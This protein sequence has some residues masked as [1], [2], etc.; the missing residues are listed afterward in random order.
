MIKLNIWKKIFLFVFVVSMAAVGLTGYWGYYNGKKS[1]KKAALAQLV[2]IRD[3]KKRQ[4]ESY[5]DERLSDTEVLSGRNGLQDFLR[6]ISNIKSQPEN[7]GKLQKLDKKF[8]KQFDKTSAFIREKMGFY[9][10]FI[11]DTNGNIIY[12]AAKEDDLGS[13]LIHGK[14]NHSGLSRAYIKGLK[15][16]YISDFEFYGASN[17]K[18]SS[19]FG[20]PIKDDNGDVLGVFATQIVTDEINDIMQE[21]SGLG[22]TGETFLIGHDLF[23]RSDSRFYNEQTALIKKVEVEAPR[24]GLAGNTGTMWLLDYRNVPVLNAY[25]PINIPG[26]HWAIIAKMDET[27]ALA[28]AYRFRNLMLIGAGILAAIVLLVSYI[29]SRKITNPINIF[30]S[31]IQEMIRASQYNTAIPVISKDEVGLLV[32]SFNKM[33]SQINE[34]TNELENNQEN[35]KNE[36]TERKQAENELKR[37]QKLKAGL[38]DLSLV[39]QGEQSVST[40]AKNVI[41]C[42]VGFLK[43]PIAAFFVLNIQSKYHRVADFG[44]PGG[45]DLPDLF[46]PGEGYIGQAAKNGKPILVDNI[47]EHIKVGFGFGEIP[48]QSILLVPLIHNKLAIGVLELGSFE[49]FTTDQREWIEEAIKSISVVLRSNIDASERRRNAVLR[50]ED[51]A[52][53]KVAKQEADDANQAK[54]DFLANMSHEIRT[55]MNAIMGMSQLCLRTELTTKQQD[56]IQKTYSAARSLLGIINDILDFSK[57]EAGK[58]DIEKV[59]F[60]LEDIFNNLSNLITIKAQDKGL[61]FLFYISPDVPNF[62]KGD[63]LRLGQVL[64]NL[65][66]NA[67]KFT[68]SGEILVSV[69]VI[70]KS[71]HDATLQFSVKDSGIGMTKEQISNLF[72]PFS[73]ADTSTTRKYGGTGLGLTISKRLVEM[74]SGKIW[75]ESEYGNGSSFIFTAMLGISKTKDKAAEIHAAIP[76]LKGINVMVVDDNE[77]LQKLFEK[78]LTNLSFKVA[79]APTGETA[80]QLLEEADKNEPY[81]LLFMDFMLPGI[82]GIETTKQIKESAKIVNKPKVVMSTSRP[83]EE[84]EKQ[85]HG[86]EYDAYLFK[87]FSKSS[88]FDSIMTAYGRDKTIRSKVGAIPEAD[89]ASIEK[90]RGA[91]ILLVED[92]EINQQ[93][94]TEL[95]EQAGL[96]VEVANDGEK[97]VSYVVAGAYD[98]VLMDLQ[99]PKKDGFEATRDIRAQDRFKELPII[100]MTANAMAGDKEKCLAAGMNDHVGKPININD[101]FSKLSKWIKPIVRDTS[102]NA[103][104]TKSKVEIDVQLP[105]LTGID[106]N[107]GISRVGGNKNF[108]RKLLIKFRDDYAGVVNEIKTQLKEEDI[109]TAERTAH[110]LKGVAGNI[111]AVEL[112][113]SAGALETAIREG[114]TDEHANLLEAVNINLDKVQN[115]LKNLPTGDV[116]SNE[117][118]KGSID[119]DAQLFRETLKKLEPELKTR[120]PKRCAPL[121]EDILKFSL[122]KN[123]E[124]EVS[125]L[126][127]F[128]KKYKFKD[129][130]AVLESIMKK[131]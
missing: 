129:A 121:I 49:S 41:T 17:Q 47:P 89:Q 107:L 44:Y 126:A 95:L 87:P 77:S 117:N 61:E 90:V 54:S 60:K 102:I 93:V 30:T 72:K 8:R 38:N 111:G 42:L 1:L 46:E 98:A 57:I 100:A 7:I 70:E 21:R 34:Q 37:E 78:Y 103:S 116:N 106:T 68:K 4:I 5:F 18:I 13:N 105:A 15:E 112:Q 79:V 26:V 43:L 62:L 96:Q 40:L 31:K 123:I 65:S 56:Y 48:P 88:L 84:I 113:K 83:A 110:T 50:K 51:E 32:E 6:N 97:A 94:A 118:E 80:L 27:E 76:E 28:S 9:D 3:I 20:V 128:I 109:K 114:K 85:A 39:M 25:A 66:N 73:Q 92:N 24:R 59:D 64:T 71:R 19:F 29:L 12:T 63:P 119:F 69:D 45:N 104:V 74:M 122:P 14:Y 99:M 125:C 36:L 124:K 58:M 130:D 10:I 52:R 2:S 35:L 82:D 55:P 91:R 101:L 115:S 16:S 33:R 86:V 23:F 11:I 120:K 53:L 127:G 22:K 108:Y 81:K 67:L 131:L 75:V